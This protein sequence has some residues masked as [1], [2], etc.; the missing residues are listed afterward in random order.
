MG[1]S[2]WAVKGRWVADAFVRA[3]GWQEA[4]SAAKRLHSLKLREASGP[5]RAAA[6]TP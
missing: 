4:A 3:V 2:L 5:G 6:P 1:A